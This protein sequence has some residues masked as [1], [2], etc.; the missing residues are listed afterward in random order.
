MHTLVYLCRFIDVFKGLDPPLD[1][2]RKV[3]VVTSCLAV[4]GCLA[5]LN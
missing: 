5:Y 3:I 2:G 1:V 4:L